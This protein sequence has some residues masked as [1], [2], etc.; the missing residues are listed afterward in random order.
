MDVLHGEVRHTVLFADVVNRNDARMLQPSND[1]DL[2]QKT[3]LARPEVQQP[4]P[5]QLQRHAPPE[6]RLF[7]EIHGPHAALANAFDQPI[8][9]QS[10]GNGVAGRTVGEQSHPAQQFQPL[11]NP[12]NQLRML[13]A[14]P[15]H[16][17]RLAHLLSLD[18]LRDEFLE[19]V[20]GHGSA[21]ERSG[22]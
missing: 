7:G 9:P 1:L 16:R 10:L 5:N 8:S 6:R 20:I 22:G 4:G 19:N 21:A 3:L 11:A 17:R 15:L 13:G 18:E 2:A 12:G 14:Q